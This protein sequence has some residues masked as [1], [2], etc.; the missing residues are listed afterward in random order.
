M[1]ILYILTSCFN[2]IWPKQEKEEGNNENN[3]N[4]WF[5]YFF[6]SVIAAVIGSR[7]PVNGEEDKVPIP[8]RFLDLV[9]S[10]NGSVNEEQTKN[11]KSINLVEKLLEMLLSKLTLTEDENN[12]NNSRESIDKRRV[13]YNTSGFIKSLN[14]LF[15]KYLS[16]KQ[17]ALGVDQDQIQKCRGIFESVCHLLM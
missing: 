9:P 16:D 15:T 14:F 4:L 7:T 11:V 2:L 6:S 3:T 17:A 12:K 1:R 10:N 13:L 5:F 8:F